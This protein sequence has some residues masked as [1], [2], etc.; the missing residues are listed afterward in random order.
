MSKSEVKEYIETIKKLQK[1]SNNI[2]KSY[3]NDKIKVSDDIISEIENMDMH[4]ECCLNIINK[5]N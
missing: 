5:N 1:I 3:Y 2:I 4:I